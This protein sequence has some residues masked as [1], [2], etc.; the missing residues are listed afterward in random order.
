[1]S[2]QNVELVR[3]NWDLWSQGADEEL[4]RELAPDVEW[5]HNSAFT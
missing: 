5:H 1:M 2:K 4:A 3:R